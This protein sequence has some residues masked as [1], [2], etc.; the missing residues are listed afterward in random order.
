MPRQLVDIGKFRPGLAADS[1][2]LSMIIVAILGLGFLVAEGT[3]LSALGIQGVAFALIAVFVCG[4]LLFHLM[5]SPVHAVNVMILCSIAIQLLGVAA[6]WRSID[7]RS[8]G[9]FLVGG[10][11]GVPAGVYLLLHL[12]TATYRNVIGGLLVVYGGYLFP[13]PRIVRSP[14]FRGS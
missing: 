2:P 14:P 3:A 9:I 13:I 5:E 12:P 4:A 10:F 8:L 11:L 1:G 7:W 6:L